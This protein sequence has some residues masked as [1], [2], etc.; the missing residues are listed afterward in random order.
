MGVWRALF[1]YGIN[2]RNK[3]T[4]HYMIKFKSVYDP[5]DKNDGLRVLATR[6]RGRGMKADRYDVWMP[7]L[8]PSEKLLRDALCERVPWPDFK[9]KYKEEVLAS[10]DIDK[11]NKSIL[12]H[13]QKFTLRLIKDLS[14][15]Q[16]V[17]FMCHCDTN[18]KECH[19]RV[20]E[21]LIKSI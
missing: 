5:I 1:I 13:G 21:K 10:S 3:C 17:T 8:G 19:L 12:N 9:K 2:F 20:L 7:N 4:G 11:K 16:D 18:D 6:F 14:G 15:K